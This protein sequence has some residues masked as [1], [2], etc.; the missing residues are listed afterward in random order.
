MLEKELQRYEKRRRDFPNAQSGSF[1][2]CL[3]KTGILSK[4]DRNPVLRR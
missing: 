4:A 3:T 1:A 2:D